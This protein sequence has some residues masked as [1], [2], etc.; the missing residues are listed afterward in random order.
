MYELQSLMDKRY[1]RKHHYN[2]LA[3]GLNY[4]NAQGQWVESKE[5][6]DV[7][8]QGGAAATQGQHQV[9]FPGNIYQGQIEMVTPDGLKLYS[10]PVGLSYDDGTNTVMI[11]VLTN[12]TGV[13]VSSNQVIYPN[14]FT[15]FAADLRY[16]Y[17]KAGFEQDIILREQPPAP[18]SLNLNPDT[19]RIQ[20]L[21]EFFNPPQPSV[22]ATAVPTDAGSL[23]DET[24]DFGQMQMGRGKAFLLGTNSPGVQVDKQ[25][26]L[27]DGRQF[28]VEEVLTADMADEL[29]SLPLPS[30]QASSATTGHT[31]ARH[32]TL[33]PQRMV[34]TVPACQ[35]DATGQSRVAGKRT[36][37]GLHSRQ[38]QPDQLHLSCRFHILHHRQRQPQRNQ[39][40]F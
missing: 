10:R 2:E 28:L 35:A 31:I 5:E 32:L 12:S 40:H 30:T 34:K 39:Q 11:A 20:V 15:S 19:T 16:T 9:Y 38:Y 25:W 22:R 17:T 13:L 36:C 1:P 8:P 14:A 33:P 7:L 24:L 18:A 3:T 27:L 29:G 6:I 26:L 21:T 37:A 23:T 4:K